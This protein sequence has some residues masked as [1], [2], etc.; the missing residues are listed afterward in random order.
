[1]NN[2]ML[3][4]ETLDTGSD[5]VVIGIG[6]VV[7]DPESRKLGDTFY[8]EMSDDIDAQQRLGRTI[9]GST[10]TWWM[11][12]S[13]E[14]KAIFSKDGVSPDIRIP[15]YDALQKFKS[16][17]EANGAGT[18]MLWGNGANFD[19][20]ILRN[21]YSAFGMVAPWKFYNDRCHRTVKDLA[22]TLH[23]PEFQDR[24]GTHHNA[25]DDAI[26]QAVHLQRA[27]KCLKQCDIGE[28][29]NV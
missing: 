9:S 4:L 11:G 5:A 16:F 10:L 24:I 21:L 20:V 22:T 8:V 3:D 14:A 25:L 28:Q 29:T 26:T 17:V 27:F 15:T 2:I 23:N 7:F 18:A 12:Q 19:N 13:T 1:M 6:A